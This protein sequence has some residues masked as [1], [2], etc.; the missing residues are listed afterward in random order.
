MIDQSRPSVPDP[1]SVVPRLGSDA[2][3]LPYVKFRCVT[4][5]LARLVVPAAREYVGKGEYI[6]L[7]VT[8][9]GSGMDE[10]TPVT[11]A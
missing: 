2:R 1:I 6:S 7:M 11:G 8:D 5:S 9:I 10:T 4:L 3:N